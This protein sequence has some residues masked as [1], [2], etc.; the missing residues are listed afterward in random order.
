MEIDIF[1]RLG[2][3][4]AAA[5]SLIDLYSKRTI[6]LSAICLYF[7]QNPGCAVIR[8]MATL[9]AGKGR[10]ISCQIGEFARYKDTSC[11]SYRQSWFLYKIN[12]F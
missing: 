10:S 3:F 6:A 2:E 1:A 5:S 12:F 7:L 8:R 4:T 9:A 11:S